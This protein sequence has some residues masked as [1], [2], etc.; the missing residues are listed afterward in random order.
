MKTEKII[1]PEGVRTLRKRERKN[2]QRSKGRQ[3]TG[4]EVE[5]CVGIGTRKTEN[6]RV[7]PKTHRQQIC[8]R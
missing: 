5:K 2:G 4:Y 3:K 7:G 6:D 1:I 8:P